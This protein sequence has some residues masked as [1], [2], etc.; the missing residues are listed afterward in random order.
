MD[1]TKAWAFL[2]VALGIGAVVEELTQTFDLMEVALLGEA[3]PVVALG[4]L[5]TGMFL[6][7]FGGR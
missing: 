7:L 5:M 3:G 2:I 4:L 1:I 6:I